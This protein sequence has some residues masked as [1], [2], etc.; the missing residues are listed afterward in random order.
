MYLHKA[1]RCNS[2]GGDGSSN[3]G[4]N[5]DQSQA[6]IWEFLVNFIFLRICQETPLGLGGP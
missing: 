4:C 2:S 5:F 6:K 3:Y 1:K